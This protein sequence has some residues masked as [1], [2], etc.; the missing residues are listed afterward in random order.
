[1]RSILRHA[2]RLDALHRGPVRGADLKAPSA[3]DHLTPAQRLAVAVTRIV[4]DDVR[5]QEREQD[6]A[7][8]LVDVERTLEERRRR[9]HL[10]GPRS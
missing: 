10:W 5:R 2:V 7:R 3:A 8:R 1:M 9:R 6:I 4:R